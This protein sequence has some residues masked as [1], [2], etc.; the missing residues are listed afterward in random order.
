M[1][2]IDSGVRDNADI[3]PR[4][5]FRKDFTGEGDGDGYGH[6]THTAGIIASSGQ[7][8]YVAGATTFIGM[9][10]GA[11]IIDLKVL[12]ADGTGEV[13]NVIA[14]IDFA[15]AQRERLDIRIINLSLGHPV[16]D[17]TY[18][19]DPLAKAVERAVKAGIVVICSA[20]NLGKTD[21]GTPVVGA[22]VSPGYTPGAITVGALNTRGTV[23]RSDDA[24]TSYSSRGPVGNPDDPSTWGDQAGPGRAEQ[25]DRLDRRGPASY[26]WNNYPE[27]QVYG[28]N[29]GTYFT[30]SGV[31]HGGRGGR[32]TPWRNCSRA[33]R[34]SRR[35]KSSSRCGMEALSMASA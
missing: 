28:A 16:S 25:R 6:G 20:G 4:V 17:G 2:L 13:V 19:D 15:V 31:E 21:D 32:R 18:R 30:L 8:S 12:G 3:A 11:E 23:A 27:R 24:V 34:S 5:R 33:W 7:G 1:A 10:P 26:L 9:A 14:A 29:G 22:I 35:G